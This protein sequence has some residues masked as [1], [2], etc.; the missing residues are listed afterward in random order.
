MRRLKIVFLIMIVL[1]TMFGCESLWNISYSSDSTME[2]EIKEE[3]DYGVSPVDFEKEMLVKIRS[4]KVTT[5]WG[6]MSDPIPIG[7]YAEWY[8][9][10]QNME[11]SEKREYTI[12][13]NVNYSIRGD[14]ALDLYNAFNSVD[15]YYYDDFKPRNGYELAIVNVTIHLDSYGRDPAFLFPLSFNLSTSS[16]LGIPEYNQETYLR[17]GPSQEDYFVDYFHYYNLLA[18]YIYPGAEVTANLVYEV[19]VNQ[20]ILLGFAD[21]WFEI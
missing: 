17:F 16:G 18:G 10:Q 13:M 11:E 3:K 1:V 7:E 6:D 19:P 5:H 8:I 14:K 4:P 20:A 2:E 21:V 12:R 15:D 9:Y